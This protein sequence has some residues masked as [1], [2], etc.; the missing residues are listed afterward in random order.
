VILSL[1]IKTDFLRH[2]V[3]TSQ[4]VAVCARLVVNTLL[5]GNG[6]KKRKENK[7]LLGTVPP[8]FISERACE[9]EGPL[10]MILIM[11]ANQYQG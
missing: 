8:I 5:T 3:C 4:M 7:T 6:P 9:M 10:R 2:F 1:Q 11:R